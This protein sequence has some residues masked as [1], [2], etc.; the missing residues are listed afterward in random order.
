MRKNARVLNAF[1]LSILLIGVIVFVIGTHIEPLK[2]APID[3]EYSESIEES[4]GSL[5]DNTVM[6]K[7]ENE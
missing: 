2:F 4:L 7:L 5:D 1:I 3:K 6:G